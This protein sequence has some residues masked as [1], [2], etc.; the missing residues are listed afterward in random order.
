[1][2]VK[3]IL[4]RGAE[5]VEKINP[6][7]IEAMDK[8]KPEDTVNIYYTGGLKE[9]EPRIIDDVDKFIGVATNVHKDEDG[10]YICDCCINEFLN[11][12]A[13]FDNVIDNITVI[14]RTKSNDPDDGDGSRLIPEVAQLVIYNL[15]M[16]RQFDALQEQERTKEMK[17]GDVPFPRIGVNPLKGKDFQEELKEQVEKFKRGEIDG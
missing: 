7:I 3:N 2:K 14:A 11:A 13:N 6:L 5:Q 16:K 9:R 12:S 15:D 10:N 8:L 17:E 1:M 4:I